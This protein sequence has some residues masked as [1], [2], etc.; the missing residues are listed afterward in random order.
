LVHTFTGLGRKEVLV[1]DEWFFLRGN[2]YYKWRIN[3]EVKHLGTKGGKAFAP[4]YSPNMKHYKSIF[5]AIMYRNLWPFLH[6]G[7]QHGSRL[8]SLFLL[9]G[10]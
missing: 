5:I 9:I 7:K 2:K 1:V 4:R 6:I 8:G 3:T 10:S